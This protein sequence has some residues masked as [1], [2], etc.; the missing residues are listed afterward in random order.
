MIDQAGLRFNDLEPQSRDMPFGFGT[1]AG[2][3]FGASGG[4]TEA[5]LRYA[6][7]KITGKTL[8]ATDFTDVRGDSGLREINLDVGGVTLRL[9]VVY[10]LA[11]ARV[12]ADKV[13]TGE[14]NYDLIEVMPRAVKSPTIRTT[15][16]TRL[17]AVK[18]EKRMV[19]SVA[20]MEARSRP[21][22]S[23]PATLPLAPTRG[24]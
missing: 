4:V 5:V 2:V 16:A 10:G 14:C 20:A 22:K 11:N 9:A 12:V 19:R 6:A 15:R 24:Q 17:E 23:I 8:H 1:G 18:A 7:E 13:K 21:I 3:I